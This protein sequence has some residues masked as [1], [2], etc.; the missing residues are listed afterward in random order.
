MVAMGFSKSFIILGICFRISVE[1]RK[2]VAIVA[3][4][5]SDEIQELILQRRKTRR[6]KNKQ[7]NQL[8]KQRQG[9][10][11]GFRIIQNY[12]NFYFNIIMPTIFN[13]SELTDDDLI[14]LSDKYQEKLSRYKLMMNETTERTE[15]IIYRIQEEQVRRY[16]DKHLQNFI[17]F[18]M[19]LSD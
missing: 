16:V 6:I 3:M 5:P 2:R 13:V 4:L 9:S 1:I 12:F 15:K 14:L 10:L 19:D 18:K 7:Q 11:N 17:E 8:I